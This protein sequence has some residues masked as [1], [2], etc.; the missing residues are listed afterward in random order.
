M[1]S[2]SRALA[3]KAGAAER[4]LLAIE[5]DVAA[6]RRAGVVAGIAALDRAHGV[7]RARDR[8]LRH[9]GGMRIAD[10]LVLDRAQPEALRGVV[11]RLLEPAIVE[12]QHFGLAIFE[13]ELAVVGALEA[14]RDD[15]GE[16]RAVEPGAIDEGGSRVHHCVPSMR[17]F[18]KIGNGGPIRERESPNHRFRPEAGM[19]SI[20]AR[21]PA[22]FQTLTPVRRDGRA[23]PT[24]ARWRR[25]SAPSLSSSR[26][27][28]RSR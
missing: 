26:S 15:L 6:R 25:R 5:L 16:A 24:A 22:E 11:G 17:P 20:W 10:R 23:I 21:Q 19:G 27:K 18:A 12:H 1:V 14:A 7:G 4:A 8:R 13:K 3:S 28:P 9:V 2:R